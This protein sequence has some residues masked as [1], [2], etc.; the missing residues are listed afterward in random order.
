MS[1]GADLPDCCEA[2]DEDAVAH[3]NRNGTRASVETCVSRLLAMT[4]LWH[5]QPRLE[6]R[7]SQ[8]L[9]SML[10]INILLLLSEW[11]WRGQQV[12]HCLRALC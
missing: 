8:S 5:D 1:G 10:N 11:T 12:W 9:L 3:D 7:G 4:D 6:W 2:R